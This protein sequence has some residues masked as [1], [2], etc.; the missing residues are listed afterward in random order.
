M[1]W[2][3]KNPVVAPIVTILTEVSDFIDM[4]ATVAV[5]AG[6]IGTFAALFGAPLSVFGCIATLIF[7]AFAGLG[8]EPIRRTA[9]DLAVRYGEPYDGAG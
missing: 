6:I 2:R 7:G 1:G 8:T 5:V 3:L 4:I 9:A